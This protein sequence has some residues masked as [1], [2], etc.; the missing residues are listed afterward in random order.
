MPKQQFVPHIAVELGSHC[1]K[2]SVKLRGFVY[3]VSCTV[4]LVV[5]FYV[6]NI[7]VNLERMGGIYILIG[8]SPLLGICKA[9]TIHVIHICER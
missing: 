6:Y 5:V 1:V 7:D 9:T 2:L 4:S 3:M 8:L